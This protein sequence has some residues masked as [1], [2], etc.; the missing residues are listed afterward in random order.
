MGHPDQTLSRLSNIRI[1]IRPPGLTLAEYTSDDS[2]CVEGQ[3]LCPTVMD[4]AIT[5]LQSLELKPFLTKNHMP[6]DIFK[7]IFAF[8]NNLLRSYRY[9]ISHHQLGRYACALEYYVDAFDT[10]YRACED[11]EHHKRKEFFIGMLKQSKMLERLL[12]Y[13]KDRKRYDSVRQPSSK[14]KRSGGTRQP[15][16]IEDSPVP[17]SIRASGNTQQGPGRPDKVAQDPELE[18]SR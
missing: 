4:R 8:T 3:F 7:V 6:T 2:I 15:I 17:K 13:V 16:V 1:S 12:D 18:H 10:T 14:R 9:E 11:Q 5:T